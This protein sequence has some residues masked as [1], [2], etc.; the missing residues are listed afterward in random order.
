MPIY[1]EFEKE[2]D[3]MENRKYSDKNVH[4]VKKFLLLF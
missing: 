1:D 4:S 3:L 2:T